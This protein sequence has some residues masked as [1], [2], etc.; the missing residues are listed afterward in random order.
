MLTRRSRKEA[1]VSPPSPK[2]KDV[3][4][5]PSKIKKTTPARGKS[6]S[7]ERKVR[8]RSRSASKKN[9]SIPRLILEKVDVSDLKSSDRPRRNYIHL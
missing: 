4:K 6:K 1:A 2:K 9:T 5:S 7:V 3:S 8:N